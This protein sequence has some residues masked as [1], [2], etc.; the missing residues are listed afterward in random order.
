[1]GAAAAQGLLAMA[2][3]TVADIQ[4]AAERRHRE[5]VNHLVE[6]NEALDRIAAAL[7]EKRSERDE[8]ERI[9]QEALGHVE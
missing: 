6:T 1:M 2:L 7:E 8:N 5:L 4:E 9:E 3:K